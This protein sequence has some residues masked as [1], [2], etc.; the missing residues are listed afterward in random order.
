VPFVDRVHLRYVG[1]GEYESLSPTVYLWRDGPVERV[2]T[3]SA[4]TRSDLASTPR[5]MWWFIPPTGTYEDAAFVH[6]EGCRECRRAYDAGRAPAMSPR[7]VDRLFRDILRE[8]DRHARA[9]GDDAA[10]I[11]PFTRHL[12][13]VG[14][15]WGARF[16]RARSAGWWRDAWVVVPTS[17]V[18]FVAVCAA[19]WGAD[20]LVHWIF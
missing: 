15:R 17:A 3:I 2:V 18:L 9:V 12:L 6:D 16:N 10:R 14:V 8:S 13:W 4:G 19:V 1:C 7:D 11:R 20:R 5:L